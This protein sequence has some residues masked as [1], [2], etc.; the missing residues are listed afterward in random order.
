MKYWFL[1]ST[2]IL[3][4]S[5]TAKSICITTPTLCNGCEK[6]TT[7]DIEKGNQVKTTIFISLFLNSNQR[8]KATKTTTSNRKQSTIPRT[9][10]CETNS[11]INF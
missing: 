7:T 3:I 5:T 10:P 4:I 9:T 1:I 6:L 11:T 8:A 2:I